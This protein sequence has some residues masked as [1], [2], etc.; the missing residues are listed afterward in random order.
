[1]CKRIKNVFLRIGLC[2]SGCFCM[3]SVCLLMSNIQ[4]SLEVNA[5]N[6]K[7]ITSIDNIDINNCEEKLE[8]IE[9]IPQEKMA[10]NAAL[11]DDMQAEVYLDSQGS[12]Y[13]YEDGELI[14]YHL[15]HDEDIQSIMNEKDIKELSYDYLKTL[16]MDENKYTLD[17]C[18]YD[19]YTKAYK[20]NYAFWKNGIKTTDTVCI[21]I[22]GDGQLCGYIVSNQGVFDNLNISHV[23][24]EKAFKQAVEKADRDNLSKY[25]FHECILNVSENGN[26]VYNIYLQSKVSEEIEMIEIECQ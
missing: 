9:A 26:I 6:E 3:F 5:R 7:D 21:D 14:G 23:K 4:D 25:V 8:D 20:V 1:M 15:N 11:S 22:K 18:F 12:D 13:I 19:E 10:Y 16:V 24:I 17:V 2:L